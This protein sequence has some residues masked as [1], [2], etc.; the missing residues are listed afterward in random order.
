MNSSSDLEDPSGSSDQEKG[1]TSSSG[2]T[3]STDSVVVTQNMCDTLS[4]EADSW[5]DEEDVLRA[6]AALS[7]SASKV[8]IS[9]KTLAGMFFK[10]R[11]PPRAKL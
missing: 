7:L 6:M 3:S 1:R 8:T 5:V 11:P 2:T 10:S 4:N 9:R